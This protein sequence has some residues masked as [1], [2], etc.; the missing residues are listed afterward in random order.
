M[1]FGLCGPGD[2]Q[3]QGYNAIS[4]ES[5]AA[6]A[7]PDTFLVDGIIVS[8]TNHAATDLFVSSTVNNTKTISWNGVNGAFRLG[9]NTTVSNVFD[10]SGD[11][12]LMVWG[13]LVNVSNATVWQNYNGGVINMGWY[14]NST[15]DN[16][17]VDGVYVVKTDWHVPASTSW[18][19]E[20]TD[21]I[22]N[23]N[24]AVIASLMSPGTSFGASHPS[25]YRNIFVEDPP[26]VLF[27][28][29]IMP[30]D[31]DLIG[32]N[33][34]CPAPAVV[35]TNPAMVYLN[36]ENLF[37]PASAI[38]NSIGFQTL[39]TGYALTG[40]MSIGLTNVMLKLSNGL[41]APLT[42]ANFPVMGGVLTSGPNVSVN[43]SFMLGDLGALFWAW[44]LLGP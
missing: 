19:T 31:C 38:P 12:S 33:G 15:G 16:C 1:I 18:T 28:L 8:D 17:L 32:L 13:S 20:P 43:Y 7:V 25:L 26:Q 35:L 36:V 39:A 44:L 29:K 21:P 40:S 10:R 41:V 3:D 24:N 30:P 4:W 11:D 42:S 34:T 6:T 2:Y 14:D 5:P 9:D 22:A 37:S 23:Q 27:S